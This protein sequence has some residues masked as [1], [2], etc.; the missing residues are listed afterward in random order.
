VLNILLDKKLPNYE[1]VL[2]AREKIRFWM[3][4]WSRCKYKI[5]EDSI[6]IFNKKTV[7]KYLVLG[8]VNGYF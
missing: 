3:N 8:F 5:K 4:I 2:A 7:R 1:M 6:M